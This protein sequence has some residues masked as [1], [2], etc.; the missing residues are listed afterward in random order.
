MHF[1]SP[2]N[3]N[4]NPYKLGS[5]GGAVHQIKSDVRKN[6]DKWQRVF[7]CSQSKRFQVEPELW[8]Q[9][10]RIK[11]WSER[12]LT[13]LTW[14][15]QL[16]YNHAGNP[17]MRLLGEVPSSPCHQAYNCCGKWYVNS[18]QTIHTKFSSYPIYM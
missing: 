9:F 13:T 16:Q 8:V 3:S 4:P 7:Y 6:G 14:E 2:P 10:Y 11:G 12:R 5:S 1:V 15:L 18:S 17:E